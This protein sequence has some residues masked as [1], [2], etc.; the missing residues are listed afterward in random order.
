MMEDRGPLGSG[1]CLSC[2]FKT[3][4]SSWLEV[5]VKSMHRDAYTGTSILIVGF[6]IINYISAEFIFEEKRLNEI[7]ENKFSSKITRYTVVS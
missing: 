6:I 7:S 4:C 3:P 1:N 2:R 5:T